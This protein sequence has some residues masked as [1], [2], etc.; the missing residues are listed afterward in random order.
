MK[1]NQTR[2]WQWLMDLA[3]FTEPDRPHTRRSFSD[4]FLQG[5]AWLTGE[6]EK[7]GLAVHIDAAGNLMGRLAGSQPELGTLMTGSHSDSVPSGG[8]F[9]GMAGVIAGLELVASWRERGYVPRHNIEVVDFLAEEPSEWGI[10]CVGSR[11]ITGFLPEN[12]QNTPHP[13]TGELLKDAVARMG[14]DVS[15][16]AKRDDVKA[17]FELHIEQGAVLEHEGLT[18]GVVSGIVGILR[19]AITFKGQAAHAGTTPMH[20]RRDAFTAAA[21]TAYK[22]SQLATQ[23]AVDGAASG[24]VYFTATC[25]QVFGFPNASNVVPGRVQIVFDIRSDHKPSME[26]F[27]LNLKRI[28]DAAAAAAKVEMIEFERMTDTYPMTCDAQLMRYISESALAQNISHRVM[29]SGAGHDAAFI[30]HIAPSAMVFVPSVDG[31]SHCPEEYTSPED[32]AAGMSVLI[33]AMERVDCK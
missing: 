31:K 5:R 23:V 27:A 15:Q 1:A 20:I 2:Y 9:D 19:L 24:E 18:V 3:T 4:T 14:G 11:G 8:R 28:A 33:E 21:E 22:A 17:F 16:L 32:F 13:K 6:M 10:S 26:Q 7:L 25:G 12:L 30:S 29:P